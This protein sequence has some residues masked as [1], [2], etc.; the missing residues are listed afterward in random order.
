M[1]APVPVAGPVQPWGALFGRPVCTLRVAAP[2]A[3]V[4]PVLAEELRRSHLRVREDGRSLR[5]KNRLAVVLNVAQLLQPAEFFSS[6]VLTV[7]V[8]EEGPAGT[9]LEIGVRSGSSRHFRFSVPDA[10][11][12][13]VGRLQLGGAAVEVGPWERWAGGRRYPVQPA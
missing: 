2:A 6:P 13:A 7:T 10:L 3:A 11:N 8:L 12:R 9:A 1:S 4:L 5:V